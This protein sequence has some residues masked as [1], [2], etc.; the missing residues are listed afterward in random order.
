[1]QNNMKRDS[2]GLSQRLPHLSMLQCSKFLIF[3]ILTISESIHKMSEMSLLSDVT[4]IGGIGIA[5]F[6]VMIEAVR[7]CHSS[8]SL[9]SKYY[10][11]AVSCSMISLVAAMAIIVA[12]KLGGYPEQF[13]SAVAGFFAIWWGVGITC[14]TVQELSAFSIPGHV[15]F[16]A[17]SAF[18]IS[19]NICFRL[20]TR[21]S[22]S[23][24]TVE[25]I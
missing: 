15:Y 4:R 22:T 10:A 20:A 2:V 14:M 16:A 21:R 6:I 12:Y 23:L 7:D 5:S 19:M 24:K 25:I 8:G 1:M 9:C 17:C 13:H 11:W 18:L 3:F